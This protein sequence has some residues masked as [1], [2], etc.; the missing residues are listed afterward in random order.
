[1]PDGKLCG[2]GD[3]SIAV[4]G[5]KQQNGP[6]PTPKPKNQEKTNSHMAGTILWRGLY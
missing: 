4:S 1:M 3:I 6:S 5:K 2:S